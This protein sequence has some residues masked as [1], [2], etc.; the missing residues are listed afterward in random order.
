MA[1]FAIIGYPARH[2]LSPAIFAAA[3]PNSRDSYDFIEAPTIE[4][5]MNIFRKGDY[6]GANVTS[7]FKQEVIQYCDH[8]DDIVS[9]A[10]A[11]N[12]II[13]RDGKI[14]GYNSD[15][16][17]VKEISATLAANR[18]IRN[19]AIVT[20][21][22]GAGRAAALALIGLGFEVAILNRTIEN[23]RNFANKAGAYYGPL[24]E[25]PTLLSAN[26]LLVHTTDYEIPYQK[27][28]DFSE[29]AIIE[30]NYKKPNLSTLICKNYISGREWLISQAIPA[31]K[32]LTTSEPDV[33]AI[34]KILE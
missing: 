30:A 4:E 14:Y 26:A 23:A 13:E 5:A 10:N 17:G 15:Y 33:A 31:F 22:G 24:S 16:Y 28:I 1:K 8:T 19:K 2:S 12:L 7:P 29:I 11:S 3:Y 9:N 32:I 20:G 18:T 34:K 25:I 21:A 27:E 6:K